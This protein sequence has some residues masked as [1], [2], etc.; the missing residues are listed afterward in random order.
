MRKKK[1]F[2]LVELVVVVAIFGVIVGLLTPA[3]ARYLQRSKVK[4]Q[5]AEAKAV[6]NAVQTAVTDLEFAERKYYYAL[7]TQTAARNYIYTPVQA[8][9]ITPAEDWY[10]YWDGARGFQSSANGVELDTSGYDPKLRATI[11]EWNERLGD[12]IHRIVKDDIVYKVWIRDYKVMAVVTASAANSRY[13]GSHPVNNFD[14]KGMGVNIEPLEHTT[15]R[16]VDL[17]WFDLDSS[18]NPA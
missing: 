10:F 7:Q 12:K 9:G 17:K 15:V 5:N 14:L 16:A 18:N 4:A 3:W 6:F 1:G 8:D 13:I 11:E 2:T